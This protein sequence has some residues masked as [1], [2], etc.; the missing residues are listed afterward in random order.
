M[1]YPK[2]LSQIRRQWEL[3]PAEDGA[4][5]S[6]PALPTPVTDRVA[7]GLYNGGGWDIVGRTALPDSAAGRTE[8]EN[9]E[10]E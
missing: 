5:R 2:V 8:G 1:T 10:S 4:G 9:D 7:F 6:S 3:L